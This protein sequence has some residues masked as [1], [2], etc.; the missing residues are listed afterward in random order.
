VGYRTSVPKLFVSKFVKS[1]LHA[2]QKLQV[3]PAPDYWRAVRQKIDMTVLDAPSLDVSR[4]GLALVADMDGVVLVIDNQRSSVADAIMLRDEVLARGGRCL[5]VVV[6]GQGKKSRKSTSRRA[7]TKE[8]VE[9][10]D[11]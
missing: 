11:A 7:L 1:N 9:Q 3:N 8:Q 4:A 10:E 2:Q 6:S 5:G